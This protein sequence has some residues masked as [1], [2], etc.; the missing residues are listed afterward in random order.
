MLDIERKFPRHHKWETCRACQEKFFYSIGAHARS[1]CLL[2][3]ASESKLYC[4]DCHTKMCTGEL[5]TFEVITGHK[6]HTF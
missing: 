1:E 3:K 2:E 5:T 6:G 4:Q